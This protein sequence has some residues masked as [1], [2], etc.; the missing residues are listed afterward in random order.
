M[1]CKYIQVYKK[2]R[3]LTYIPLLKNKLLLL[4]GSFLPVNHLLAHTA[5]NHTEIS[6][7]AKKE[8]FKLLS[9][10]EP[11]SVIA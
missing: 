9:F 6:T 7:A 11:R 1:N 2:S 10:F 4:G 3:G 5:I 8:Q